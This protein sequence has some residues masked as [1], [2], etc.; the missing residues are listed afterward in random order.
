MF[1]LLPTNE[2]DALCPRIR[3]VLVCADVVVR[4]RGLRGVPVLFSGLFSSGLI[5]VTCFLHQLQTP[6]TAWT[7]GGEP[8]V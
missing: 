6:W 1:A 5:K 2:D 3:L 8:V 4:A 7:L